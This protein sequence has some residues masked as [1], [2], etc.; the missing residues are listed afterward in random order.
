MENF[1][2]HLIKVTRIISIFQLLHVY[3][4]LSCNTAKVGI[5]HQSFSLE[6]QRRKI[7]KSAVLLFPNPILYNYIFIECIFVK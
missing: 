5:K 2:L 7:Y 1:T 4:F 6:F 3:C